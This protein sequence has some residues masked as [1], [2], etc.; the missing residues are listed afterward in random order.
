[1]LAT[2]WGLLAQAVG[3]AQGFRVEGCCHKGVGCA[4]AIM[5]VIALNPEH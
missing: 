4:K 2:T 3:V 1:M 5:D